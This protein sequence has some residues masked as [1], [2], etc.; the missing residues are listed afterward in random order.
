MTHMT[1]GPAARIGSAQVRR[2]YEEYPYPEV[3]DR[4]LPDTGWRL[5]PLEWIDALWKPG[6]EGSAPKRIL[7]AGCGTGREAFQMR[8]RFPEATIIAIDFSPRSIA[9]ARRL[10]RRERAMRRIRF[11]VGDLASRSFSRTVG[12]AFD[13]VSCHGVLSYIPGPGP[14]LMNLARCLAPEGAIYLGVNGTQHS[15]VA[16][17]EFLSAFGFNMA[18]LR[19]GPRLRALLKLLDAILGHHGPERLAN[20]NAGNLAGDLFGSVIHNLPLSHW[21]RTARRAGLHFQGSFSSQWMLDRAMENDFPRLLIP[22][23]RAEL[24]QRLEMIS[25]A[26]FHRLL[27]T[28]RAAANPPWEDHDAL[29]TCRPA[30]TSL[31]GFRPPKRSRSWHEL[32]NVTIRSPLTNTALDW[33]M[34]EWELEI[35]RQSDGQK[36]LGAVLERIPVAV[37]ATLLQR[38]LYALHQ[39]LVINLLP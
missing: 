19:D 2:V 32:R 13:F 1:T 6:F 22:R 4:G 9:I 12:G 23:S 16:G 36:T 15:S 8:R 7:I 37:R 31:Y 28:R 3:A 20:K 34:P 11:I 17:R 35:L 10:Q 18:E 39:L 25:P 5:P 21:V 14:A 29:L 33:Q 30:R 24:C 38:Q 26:A 27:F